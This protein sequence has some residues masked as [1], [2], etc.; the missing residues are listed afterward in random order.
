MNS[1]Q[2]NAPHEPTGKPPLPAAAKPSMTTRQ[3]LW[4]AVKLLLLAYAF[5]LVLLMF[6]EERLIFIPAKYPTGDW[7]HVRFAVEDA[8]F[9]APDGTKLHGWFIP[10]DAAKFETP[11]A[12]VLVAHGN[13]GNLTNRVHLVAPFRRLGAAVMLFDYR[14]YGKSEGSPSEAGVLADARAA[15]AWLAKRA[16]VAENKIVL[17]GESLGGGVAVDLAA[18]DGAGGLVLLSTFTSLPDVAARVYPWVPVRWLMRTRLDSLAKIGRYTGPVIQFHGDR[19]EIIPYELGETLFAAV[20]DP[21]KTFI[22]LPRGTHNSH[23]PQAFSDGL[24]QF[25][26]RLQ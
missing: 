5:I 16:G 3:R 2:P 14:G 15:R 7:E 24:K 26:T 6:F 21:G 12:V 23:P 8:E 25:F 19:D 9:A 11:T 17:F 10:H 13:A 22:K 1:P 4:R 18:E 20:A